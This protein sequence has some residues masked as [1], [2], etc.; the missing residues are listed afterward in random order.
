MRPTQLTHPNNTRARTRP[1]V[2]VGLE[3]STLFLSSELQ[4]KL[5]LGFRSLV[6]TLVNVCSHTQPTAFSFTS[7]SLPET[8]TELAE[9][10]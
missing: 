8:F 3:R 9:H 1:D 7:P 5:A 4:S 2:A 10:T 6:P